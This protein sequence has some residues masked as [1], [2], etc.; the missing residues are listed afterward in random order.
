[1]SSH[2]IG[3]IGYGGFGQFLHHSW[4]EL[5]NVHV[6]AIADEIPERKPKEKI[7][8][9]N[10]WQDIIK[11][12]EIEIVSIATPPSTHASIAV[13]AIS[14][15]KNL[16]IE[17]PLAVNTEEAKSIREFCRNSKKTVTV[18]YIMRYNPLISTLQQLYKSGVFGE[19]RH[20]NVENYAQDEG[21]PPEHWFWD[22][23]I[24]G[25]IMVEHGVHFIDMINFFT[26]QKAVRVK[27]V[28][29]NR[30]PLQED[31]I[32]ASVLYEDGLI[33][34]HYHSFAR[35]GF[36][37]DTSIRFNFDLAQIDLHGWIPLKGSLKVLVNSESKKQ[38][39][40]LP[41]FKKIADKKISEIPDVSRPKGWGK[42]KKLQPDR[43]VKSG[44]IEYKVREM[45]EAEFDIG[46]SKK[47]VYADCVRNI[48]KDIIAKIENPKHKLK[49]TVDDGFESLRIA[50]LAEKSA[51]KQFIH[52]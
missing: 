39:K 41:G 19:L 17:K 44:G 12:R 23:H 48:M 52:L 1:M 9:Y 7:A 4:K 42:T 43:K 35:P 3:L 13:E 25:G 50:E 33:T 21:L 26:G 2:K 11:N 51:A 10:N 36:F 32:F 47:E 15:G 24:S 27:A 28:S 16:L 30:N 37:E 34:T 49:V 18:N 20:V 40:K 29:H 8:F 38:L 5:K 31:Q 6:V 14:F 22:K 45:V 46:L